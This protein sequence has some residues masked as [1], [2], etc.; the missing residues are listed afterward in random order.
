MSYNCFEKRLIHLLVCVLV[1]VVGVLWLATWAASAPQAP[2]VEVGPDYN[3][4]AEAGQTVIYRHALTNTGET[5]DT[6][7]VEVRSTQGWPVH[8]SEGAL[9][10]GTLT[11]QLPLCVGAQ[12]TAAFQVSLTVPAD[13]RGVTEITLITATSLLSPA[14]QDTASDMTLVPAWCY[15]PLLAKR[16]PPI[17]YP[18]TLNPIGNGDGDGIYV[19]TWPQVNLAQTYSLEEDDGPGFPNPTQVYSGAETAWT[20]PEPG[21]LAGTYYYRVRAHNEWGYGAYSNVESVEVLLPDKPTLSPIDNADENGIYTVA[22][23]AAARA[24]HYTLQEDTDPNFGSPTAVYTGTQ[25]SWAETEQEPGTYY[26]RVR[27]EGPTGQSDWSN[28]QGTSVQRFRADDA[29]V[30][31]GDCTTLRWDFDNIQAIYVSFGY[32]YDKEGVPGHESRQVCPSVE[33]TYEALVVKP[34]GGYEVHKVTVDAVGSGC[35]DPVIQRFSPTTYYVY[36]GQKFSI[37][38]DVECAETVHLIIGGGTP[39]PVGGHGSKIDVT[40]SANT[41]FKLKV[42]KADGSFVYATF[43]V[44]VMTAAQESPE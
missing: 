29:S 40:I 9:P 19:V 4:S 42:E 18:A 36:P 43:T 37:F 21:K 15:L 11:L 14:V 20:V 35:A 27:A 8:L 2:G 33:T 13:A 3:Q 31:V 41:D 26:Y 10:T 6:F 7:L 25:T 32:G 16:W 5:T 1:G 17:P 30:N 12:M 24:T 38:W 22:W 28:V 23:N 34:N 39:E 44:Y